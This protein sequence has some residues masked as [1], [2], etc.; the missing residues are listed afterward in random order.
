METAR[1][2]VLETLIERFSIVSAR[3]AEQ[4]S[5]IQNQEIL[6]GLHRQAINCKNLHKF[7]S[8]LKQVA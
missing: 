6:K 7:E 4:V 1:E 3:I 2:M 5:K 8:V